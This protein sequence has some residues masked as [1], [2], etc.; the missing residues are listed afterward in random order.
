MPER[1]A[2]RSGLYLTPVNRHLAPEEISYQ[3]NDSGASALVASH[4]FAR[5]SAAALGDA[6]ELAVLLRDEFLAAMP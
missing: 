4:A 3:L 6:P 2:I 1:A 5:V